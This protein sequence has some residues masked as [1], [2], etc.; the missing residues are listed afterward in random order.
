MDFGDAFRASPF[1]AVSFRE[2]VRSVKPASCFL[3]LLPIDG[4]GKAGYDEARPEI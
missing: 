2:K 1:L 3:W 4:G